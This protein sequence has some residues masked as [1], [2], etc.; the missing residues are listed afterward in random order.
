MADY[1]YNE[2]SLK[3]RINCLGQMYGASVEDF[4]E[5]MAKVI[6]SFLERG[7]SQ[8]LSHPLYTCQLIDRL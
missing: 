5:A 4:D 8:Q 2:N 7:I 6:V 1:T 3:V